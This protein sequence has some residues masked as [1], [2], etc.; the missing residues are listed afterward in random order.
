M[1]APRSVNFHTSTAALCGDLKARD[2]AEYPI[3]YRFYGAFCAP[4]QDALAAQ[5]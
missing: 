1:S 3:S 2:S 4:D 5:R